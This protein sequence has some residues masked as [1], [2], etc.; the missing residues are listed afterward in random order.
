[1]RFKVPQNIDIED[2][3][4]G[5]LTMVQFVY[6]VIGFGLCYLII[7][8]IP[9][10]VSYLLIAPIAIFIICIDFVK[11]NERPFLLFFSSAL[12]YLAAP[13]QRFWHQ[14][15]DNDM[16]VEIYR[17]QKAPTA[18]SHKELTHEE[19]GRLASRLDTAGGK[20]LIKQ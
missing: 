11:I 7:N 1:M 6:A 18:V 19:I 2:R 16:K 20:E 4:L 9:S 17:T 15:S 13:K 8:T 5:P 12:A 3:I 10:P 14:G